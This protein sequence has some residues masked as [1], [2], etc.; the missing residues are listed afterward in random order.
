MIRI[1]VLGGGIAI[2]LCLVGIV[3]VFA[4]RPLI[5]GV[6]ELG[7]AALLIAFGAVAYLAARPFAAT[8]RSDPS[9]RA[10]SSARSWARS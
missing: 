2:Y 3:P 10:P 4:T 1:G 6:V 5:V 7:Q 8:S 9:W